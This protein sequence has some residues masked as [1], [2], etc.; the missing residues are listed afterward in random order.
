M[1]CVRTIYEALENNRKMAIQKKINGMIQSG[2]PSPLESNLMNI[3]MTSDGD[4]HNNSTFDDYNMSSNQNHWPSF[5]SSSSSSDVSTTGPNAAQ[6]AVAA[7]SSALRS[8]TSSVANLDLNLPGWT[9]SSTSITSSEEEESS[10]E[11][12]SDES[13]QLKEYSLSEVSEH[14]SP[15][16]CWLVIYDKVYDVTPFLIEH[17]GGE[18][19]MLEFA[20]RDATIPFRSSRH[21]KDS[22]DI[23]KNYLIGILPESE[24]LYSDSVENES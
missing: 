5:T 15:T 10:C 21:G 24:R 9:S 1:I 18:Y 17:P 4:D 20:G 6:V 23:L 22:F 16:D 8:L 14:S 3:M 13:T 2:I 7:L 11:V 19:I 12:C